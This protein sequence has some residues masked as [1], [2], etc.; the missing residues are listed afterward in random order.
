MPMD[1]NREKQALEQKLVRCRKLAEEFRHGETARMVR[2]ME[3]ELRQQIRELE[4]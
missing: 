3:E 1:R 2:E 4:G